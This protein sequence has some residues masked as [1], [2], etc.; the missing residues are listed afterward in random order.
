MSVAEKISTDALK[1][2]ATLA[3]NYWRIWEWVN[4][5]FERLTTQ[6]EKHSPKSLGDLWRLI[7][8]G[9]VQ[10]GDFVEFRS[11]G[12]ENNNWH[13]QEWLPKAPG[14]IWIEDN[15][16]KKSAEDISNILSFPA[17]GSWDFFYGPHAHWE[18]R[19][20]SSHVNGRSLQE[21]GFNCRSGCFR[22]TIGSSEDNFALLGLC[23]TKECLVDLAFPIVVSRQV[24][25]DFLKKRIRENA[26]EFEGVIKIQA[27]NLSKQFSSYL[28]A[29]GAEA[30]A[31]L[32]ALIDNPTNSSPV[33]GQLISPLD[34][35]FKAH[36]SHPLVTVR[37]D[38]FNKD[39][40]TK[41]DGIL[42]VS[43]FLVVDPIDPMVEKLKISPKEKEE[44]KWSISFLIGPDYQFS[45]DLHPLT[46]FDSR[47]R[48][49]QCPV[50]IGTNPKENTEG[51]ARIEKYYF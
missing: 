12:K 45:T 17:K 1:A 40:R 36:D 43:R 10:H 4:G 27:L 37:V 38:G 8:S 42:M 11:N 21:Q 24:Y 7:Y 35:A 18:A 3:C 15:L 14:K 29:V 30:N 44:L 33:F 41:A 26:V 49:F 19:Y 20:Y 32:K 22:P 16:L 46:D 47:V 31:E 39:V 25:Q 9:A 48:R 13:L 6:R 34:V 2:G 5:K 28:E 23:T 50:F 51:I